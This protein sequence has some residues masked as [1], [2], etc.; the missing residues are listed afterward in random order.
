M[1]RHTLFYCT[2]IYCASQIQCFFQIEGLCPSYIEQVCWCRFSNNIFS[3]CVYVHFGNSSNIS[4][5]FIIIFVIMIY[6]QW[7]LFLF[8]CFFRAS[9]LWHMEVPRLWVESRLQLLATVMATATWDPGL[10]CDL[11]H[12]SQQCKILNP[13]SGARDQTYI[14][15]GTSC[16]R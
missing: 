9:F 14:L 8:F 2:S 6:G 12:S 13:L 10:V 11:H 16:A 3:L 5:F 15:M 7:F 4:N 1:Y